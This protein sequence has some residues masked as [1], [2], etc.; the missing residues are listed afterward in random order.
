MTELQLHTW[1]V[2]LVFL[3][4][5]V[6][7]VALRFVVAPY[8]RHARGGWGPSLPSRL[9]WI[10]MELPA[11]VLFLLVY[12]RGRHAFEAVPLAMLCV[13]QLHYVHRTFVFP[14]RI[15]S[16][17]KRMP[18]LI[19]LLGMGFQSLNTWLNARFISELGD[20]PLQ[21]LSDPRFVVGTLLFAVG[22]AINV[23]ADN[24]LIALRR[25]ASDGYRIPQG[26]LFRWVSSPNYLGELIEWTGWALLTWSGAGLAFALY[27]AANLVPRAVSHHRWYRD[28]FPDYPRQRRAILPGLL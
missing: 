26:G 20:Y 24:A 7:A 21:W 8:G 16:T 25:A 4:A 14:F 13:W 27:T 23:S 10:L 17:G 18:V 19:M 6:T 28:N 22:F 3:L 11:V 2:R 12:L 5:A 15:R 9:G 1:L